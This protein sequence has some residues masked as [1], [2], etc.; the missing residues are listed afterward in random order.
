[1]LLILFGAVARI[2]SLGTN[3]SVEKDWVVVIAHKDKI[4]L[5]C[6]MSS[7]NLVVYSRTQLVRTR[8]KTYFGLVRTHFS[9]PEFV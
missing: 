2:T 3:I 1:M 5:A 8:D 7:L 6:K 9:E 4:S